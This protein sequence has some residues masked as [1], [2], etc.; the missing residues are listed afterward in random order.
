MSHIEAIYRNG[1]FQPLE[2]VDLPEEQR[3][4]LSVE[5]KDQQSPLVWLDGVRALQTLLLQRRGPLPDSAVEIA[6]DRQR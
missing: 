6:S 3:V 5:A 1:V 2:P 4:Q